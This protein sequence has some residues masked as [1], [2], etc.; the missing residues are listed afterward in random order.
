MGQ[1]SFDVPSLHSHEASLQEGA[2][3]K[4]DEID[5]LEFW[6]VLWQNRILIISMAVLAGVLAAA[7]TLFMPNVYK[8]ELVMVPAA[9]GGSKGKGLSAALGGMAVLAGVDLGSSNSADEDLAVLS[10]RDFLFDFIKKNNVAA[11]VFL[12]PEKVSEWSSYRWFKKHLSISSSSKSRLV[13]IS[14]E[15]KDPEKAAQWLNAL[16]ASLN[17]YLKA[18]AIE[19]SRK[20]LAYLKAEVERTSVM[21]LREVLYG[22][23][24]KEQQKAMVANTQDEYA[25]YVLDSAVA[26]EDK[27]SP[28]RAMITLLST[29]GGG[30]LGCFF[31][32]VRR[33]L[34][35]ITSN[36][37]EPL[38][39]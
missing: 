14:F 23:I 11:S 21:A 27:V 9:E 8:A 19:R 7:I 24:A 16:V 36:V 30:A 2:A 13:V 22:L 10:S 18:R 31:V 17:Q 29:L 26:P 35:Q 1:E 28:K 6:Q 34:P 39:S 25:F 3:R 12:E 37:K 38:Q 15:W 4:N 32:F 33:V 5:F 20:S